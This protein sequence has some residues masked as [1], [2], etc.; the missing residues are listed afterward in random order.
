MVESFPKGVDVFDSR[1]CLALKIANA[2]L[3][4]VVYMWLRANREPKI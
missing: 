4:I 3:M 2:N 1:L